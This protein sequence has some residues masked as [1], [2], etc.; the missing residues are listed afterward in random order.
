MVICCTAPSNVHTSNLLMLLAADIFTKLLLSDL[1]P[2][3]LCY[4]GTLELLQRA[5]EKGSSLPTSLKYR[6]SAVPPICTH[7]EIIAFY[8]SS[9]Q[10][11]YLV[12]YKRTRRST[13]LVALTYKQFAH[14]SSDMAHSSSIR[15]R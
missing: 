13:S 5:T 11:S 4:V 9:K 14:V 1:C 7:P 15:L 6:S 8:P 2:V 3:Q 10:Y 12:L